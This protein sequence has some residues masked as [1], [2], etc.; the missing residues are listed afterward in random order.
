MSFSPELIAALQSAGLTIEQHRDVSHAQAWFTVRVRDGYN[1]GDHGPYATQEQAL[2]AGV[3]F[4][5]NLLTA[6]EA[7]A[8]AARKARRQ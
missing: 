3:Q 8:R 6:S 5:S 7:N 4:L 2:V 1:V